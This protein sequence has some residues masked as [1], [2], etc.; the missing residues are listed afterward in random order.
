MSKTRPPNCGVALLVVVTLVWG[1]TFPL[2]RLVT[3]HLSGL[4]I[5][6][7]RFV[8]A[9]VCMLPFAIRASPA[10]WRDGLLLGSIALI[11]YVAQAVGLG[12]ISSNRSAFLTSTNILMVPFFGWFAGGRLRWLT[13]GA[14]ALACMGIGLMSWE[15]GGDLEGDLATLVCAVAYAIYVVMLSQRSPAHPSQHLAATQILAMALISTP[16]LLLVGWHDGS[17]TS[18][19]ARLPT[20]LPSIIYLGAIASAGMLY[21]QARGQRQLSAAKSA[22]IYALEPVFAALFGWYW[23]GESMGARALIGATLVILAVVIAEWRSPSDSPMTIGR[24]RPAAIR[25]FSAG[26]KTPG[27]RRPVPAV[28]PWEQSGRRKDARS[29]A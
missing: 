1:T 11:S 18:L 5:S 17:L 19:P 23:L 15:S 29:I 7:L 27:C 10:A 22:V 3:A 28:L 24:R 26:G 8:V 6:T 4:E 14:A 13:A 20:V 25:S 2:V 12:H 21:L 9:S 16:C